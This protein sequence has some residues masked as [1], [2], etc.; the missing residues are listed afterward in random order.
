MF[1][2]ELVILISM[3]SK[4]PLDSDKTFMEVENPEPG[5]DVISYFWSGLPVETA[6]VLYLFSIFLVIF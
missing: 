3:E 6:F 4:D 1:E 2:S 5:L